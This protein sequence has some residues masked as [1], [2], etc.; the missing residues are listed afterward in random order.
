MIRFIFI[1]AFN[2]SLLAYVPIMQGERDISTDEKPDCRFTIVQRKEYQTITDFG[3]SDC[4]SA[5]FV[6]NWPEEKAGKIAELLF[7]QAIDAHGNPQGIALSSWR[8]NLGAG[9]DRNGY[10]KDSWR[11]AASFFDDDYNL[12]DVPP[13]N[14][15]KRSRLKGQRYFLRAAAEHGVANLIAFVNS[16]PIN[17]TKNSKAYCGGNVG[18][19][20]LRMDK[21]GE[22]ADYV[23]EL[24]RLI[25]QQ[26]NITFNKISPINEPEWG[27]DSPN[28]EGCRYDN[29]EMAAVVRMLRDKMD[30]SGMVEKQILAIEAGSLKSFYQWC[31]KKE[32][33]KGM[34]L[35]E[36]FEKSSENY[37]ADKL[38]NLICGHSYFTDDVGE[39][40]IDVR[41]KLKFWLDKYSNLR[42]SNSEYC[43][44]GKTS[45]GFS[46]GKVDL[47]M[48]SAL[49]MARVIHYDMTILDSVG[50]EWW[51]AISPYNYKDGLVYVSKTAEDGTYNDSKLLW[52]LGNYSRF[53]RPGMKRVAMVRSDNVEN[54]NAY[55]SLMASAYLDASDR[56]M[57]VVLINYSKQ[58]QVIDIQ[59][60][61][62]NTQFTAL[63]YIT[64]SLGSLQ[65]CKMGNN[66]TAYKISPRSVVTF[67]LNLK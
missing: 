23:I 33:L 3:A 51:I 54:E 7:S 41:K 12:L 28:Q 48:D 52:T 50:W 4:W 29:T 60:I 15:E 21:V 42:Y 5:Q 10:I 62:S 9:S 66:D 14:L 25:E 44:L 63:P 46:G 57:V 38:P 49:F 53:V 19:T 61:G 65:P 67:V 26:D 64:D 6:G 43:I 24:V 22:F 58:S 13:F 55:E 18:S 39:G 16:P 56:L 35:R 47:G 31:D 2:V 32:Q 20:N 11:R 27:W 34:F 40:L 37:I 59:T 36:F 1:L 45:E 8:F 17:M 30:A